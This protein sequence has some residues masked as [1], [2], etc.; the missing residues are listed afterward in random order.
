MK[1]DTYRRFAYIETCLYWGG[2]VTARQ[3]GEVF[4]IAR[5]NAQKTLE[6]YRQLHPENLC[7]NPSSKRHE[8]SAEFSPHYISLE[9]RRYLNYLRGNSLSQ[10]FW[11]DE[12]W[13]SEL[14]VYDVDTLFRPQ[15]ETPVLRTVVTAMRNKQTLTLNYHA[16][17][18]IQV[19]TIAPHQ[20]VY[21]SRRYH[22]RAYCY[23]WQKFIDLV[24]SRIL[25][26]EFA[27]QDWVSEDEDEEWHQYVEL[28]FTP[29]PDLPEALKQTLLLDFRLQKN[30]Y[31]L[32]VR[33]ALQGYVLREM[34]RLD[35]KYQIPLW[36]QVI[37]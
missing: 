7:Y 37:Q 13:E 35:W 5:Q 9:P 10:Q 2:G 26:A 33:K 12:N 8:Q 27:T 24:P 6:A 11:E 30:V 32:R 15:L 22:I 16:K 4:D 18:G 1:R 31:H 3:L 34:E 19:L 14:P 23:D 21:A 36:V 28:Y 29:N 25:Q 20:M 17:V